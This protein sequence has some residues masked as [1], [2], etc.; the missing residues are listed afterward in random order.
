MVVVAP[1]RSEGMKNQVL[2]L[3]T[4]TS[5]KVE[6]VMGLLSAAHDHPRAE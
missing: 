2:R 3:F 1:G 5:L 4:L 6:E